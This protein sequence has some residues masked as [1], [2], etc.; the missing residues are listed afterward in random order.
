MHS[1]ELVY[2][3]LIGIALPHFALQN[4]CHLVPMP[5]QGESN[6]GMST[7]QSRK[8][9]HRVID[10]RWIPDETTG[11]PIRV[12]S[13]CHVLYAKS[14]RS[15]SSFAG[16]LRHRELLGSTQT[17]DTTI[18]RTDGY[19]GFETSSIF[20]LKSRCGLQEKTVI[21][22]PSCKLLCSTDRCL[23]R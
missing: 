9:R 14:A 20:N 11:S 5:Y 18:N 10:R 13:S 21:V 22:S 3:R 1:I 7:L 16:T 6:D 4:T 23:C 19:Q 12:V 17:A 2:I 15:M 8:S